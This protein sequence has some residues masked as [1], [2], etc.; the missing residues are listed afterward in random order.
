MFRSY[1]V[2]NFRSY[3]LG[4]FHDLYRGE[5]SEAE[6]W[7]VILIRSWMTVNSGRGK[8]HEL[9]W[10]I[11]RSWSMWNFQDLEVEEFSGAVGS[12]IFKSWGRVEHFQGL[13]SKKN[14]MM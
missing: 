9:G 8:F 1:R 14:A 4:N 6:G 2:K 13:E 7:G 3:R 10:R 5:F 11:F 12:G